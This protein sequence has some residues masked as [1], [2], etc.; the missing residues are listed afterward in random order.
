M[1]DEEGENDGAAPQHSARGVS[2]IKIGFLDIRDGTGF[3][4]KAPELVGGPDVQA[5]G[6]EQGDARS[7]Q[8]SG[9]SL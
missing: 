6:D 5:N 9:E 7:P 3:A 4:L 1:E 2:G 8:K